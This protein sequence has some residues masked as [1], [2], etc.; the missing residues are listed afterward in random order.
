M[1]SLAYFVMALLLVQALLGVVAL[2]FAI[3][4]RAK[5]KFRITSHV[6]I[7]LLALQ[8]FWGF[9]VAPAFGYLSLAFLAIA[10]VVRY[11]KARS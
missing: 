10:V 6:L 3:L 2:T 7:G 5:G 11:L 9:S 1:E 4:N 8:M